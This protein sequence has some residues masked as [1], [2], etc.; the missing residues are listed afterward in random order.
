MSEDLLDNADNLY[1]VEAENEDGL[2]VELEES[3][4]SNLAGLIE[5]RFITAEEARDYDESRWINAYHN[6]RGVYPKDSPFRESEKSKV[7]IKITKTK[8][9]AAYGQLI[10][11]ILEQV[12]FL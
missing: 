2:N 1:F 5:A 10:D 3:L 7:F 4:R 8:V 12:S 9:L 11:V 6:F